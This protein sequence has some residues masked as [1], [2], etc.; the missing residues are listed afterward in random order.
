MKRSTVWSRSLTSFFS[1]AEVRW[2]RYHPLL[3]HAHAPQTLVQPVDHLVRPQ[4]CVLKVLVVVS[5][6]KVDNVL[7]QLKWECHVFLFIRVKNTACVGDS[8]GEERRAVHQG[9]VVV[10]VDEV[11]HPSGFVTRLGS[12]GDLDVHCVVGV[13]EVDN[14]NVKHQHG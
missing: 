12:V 5:E 3:S 10:V 1:V 7:D 4:H 9:A 14:L 6:D 8:R 13:V 11:V 2:H